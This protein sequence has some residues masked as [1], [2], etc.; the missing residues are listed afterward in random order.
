MADR[1]QRDRQVTDRAF[2]DTLGGDVDAP[3]RLKV[4][5]MTGNR[6]TDPA[7]VQ[8]PACWPVWRG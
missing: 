1:T 5:W 3:R 7:G 4:G 6:R 8:P 2:P